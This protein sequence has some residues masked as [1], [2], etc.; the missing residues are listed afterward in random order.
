[1]IEICFVRSLEKGPCFGWETGRRRVINVDI[2][3]T[4]RSFDILCFTLIW[5]VLKV[6]TYHVFS[7][8]K[9]VHSAVTCLCFY[10]SR[11]SDQAHVSGLKY[12]FDTQHTLALPLSLFNQVVHVRSD[13]IFCMDD[14]FTKL[15]FY[16]PNRKLTGKEMLDR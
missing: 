6:K 10:F 5:K 13:L 16:N 7:I 1:M 3:K 2:C 4:C 14:E 15:R 9:E 12:I 11:D 8:G